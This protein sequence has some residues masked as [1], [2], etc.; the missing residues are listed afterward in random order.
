MLTFGL[1]CLTT[2]CL[3]QRNS[4]SHSTN[5]PPL[6]LHFFMQW[7]PK[8]IATTQVHSSEPFAISGLHGMVE[9]RRH[10]FHA[11]VEGY[12][13]GTF[14]FFDGYLELE[15]PSLPTTLRGSGYF[16]LGWFVLSTNSDCKPFFENP[17]QNS[18]SLATL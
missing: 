8:V 4:S 16:A 2:A 3:V 12:C 7:P 10:K 13:E 18:R 5:V 1:V 15:K 14:N 6:F 11:K 9:A 17:R